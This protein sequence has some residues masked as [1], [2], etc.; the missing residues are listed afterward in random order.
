MI[1]GYFVP[2][3]R[4]KISHIP[5]GPPS[6]RDWKSDS[7]EEELIEAEIN[8]GKKKEW[9][10]KVKIWKEALVEVTNLTRMALKNQVNVVVSGTRILNLSHSQRLIKTTNFRGL[11]NLKR[12]ILKGR[13]LTQSISA[14]V[15]S[16]RRQPIDQTH[17]IHTTRGSS[18]RSSILFVK[19]VNEGQNINVDEEEN[20][21]LSVG[22]EENDDLSVDDEETD[23]LGQRWIAY[24]GRESTGKVH[25]GIVSTGGFAGCGEE[26]RGRGSMLGE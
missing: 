18:P 8:Q 23:D 16:A 6:S 10:K 7:F 5:E 4:K 19:M 13:D 21:G 2:L 26:W 25:Q 1:A 9:M 24:K 15:I 14:L 12:L 3:M 22:Q 11:P 20:D 17:N